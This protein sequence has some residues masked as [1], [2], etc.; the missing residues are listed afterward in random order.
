[1]AAHV[2]VA[3]EQT[4]PPHP[5]DPPYQFD[6]P[7]NPPPE[8]GVNFTVPANTTEALFTNNATTVRLQT[9]TV[10]GTLKV[11]PSFA[12][13]GGYDLTP[14]APLSRVRNAPSRKN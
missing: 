2:S 12:T 3:A 7:W 5:F 9:G 8:E 6:P 4:E 14:S 10:A 13:D 1:M 11:I